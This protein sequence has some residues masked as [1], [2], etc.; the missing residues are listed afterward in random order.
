[1]LQQRQINKVVGNQIDLEDLVGTK[2]SDVS[3]HS[4]VW[5]LI[6]VIVTINRTEPL[7][8]IIHSYNLNKE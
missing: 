2:Y 4:I 8:E 7:Q 6:S 3:F 5:V 1:M